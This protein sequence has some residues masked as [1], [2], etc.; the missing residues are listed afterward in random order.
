MTFSEI[1][2][3]VA[4]GFLLTAVIVCMPPLLL[5]WNPLVV[6]FLLFGPLWVIAATG[7]VALSFLVTGQL[8]R[9]LGAVIF[10]LGL[11]SFPPLLRYTM[12]SV[13]FAGQLASG[14]IK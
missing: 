8:Y 3:K 6:I 12:V 13:K 4:T 2:L 14:H 10:L 11:L 7:A 1:A 9:S 5:F